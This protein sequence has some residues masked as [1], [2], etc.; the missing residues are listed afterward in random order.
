MGLAESAYEN[1]TTT[2]QRRNQGPTNSDR[3]FG[4]IRCIC[5]N[6]LFITIR[7]P[8]RNATARSQPQRQ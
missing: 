8:V 6:R 2:H 3:W 4:H 5:W 1:A 7:A